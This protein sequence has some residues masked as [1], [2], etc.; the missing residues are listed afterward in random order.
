[1]KIFNQPAFH[2]FAV[3]VS[4][5]KKMYGKGQNPGNRVGDIQAEKRML[6]LENCKDPQHAEGARAGQRHEHR[7]DRIA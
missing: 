5:T 7:H 2:Y 3:S 1:M 6:N 4:K